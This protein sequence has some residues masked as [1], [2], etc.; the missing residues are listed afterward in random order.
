MSYSGN[1]KTVALNKT[2]HSIRNAQAILQYG[3]GAMIDFPDQT[4]MTT[5][6]KYWDD[7]ITKIHDERL[8]KRLKVG[9]FGSPKNGK[10]NWG[11]AFTRFPEWYFCPKCRFF[12]PIK[13]WNKD[14]LKAN[15]KSEIKIMKTPK[16]SNCR[17]NLVPARIVTACTDGHIN[18]FPWIEW[19]HN[20]RG[21][22]ICDNP[23]LK[24]TMTQTSSVGLEGVST[25]CTNCDSYATLKGAFDQNIFNHLAEKYGEAYYCNGGMPWK[26]KKEKCILFPKVLQRGSSSMYFPSIISSLVIPP[27]SEKIVYE[28]EKSNQFSKILT[29][30]EDYDD[31]EFEKRVNQ[32]IDNWTEQ[33]FEE[34]GLGTFEAIK[35]ILLRKINIDKSED[36]EII[37]NLDYKYEEYQALNGEIMSSNSLDNDFLREEIS[38]NK[39]KLPFIKQLSLVH[40]IREVRALT[41]FSRVIPA[42]NEE[43]SEKNSNIMTIKE[44]NLDWY[45]AYEVRGEGIFLEFKDELIKK[46][47]ESSDEI[48]AR[49]EILKNNY[50]KSFMGQNTKKNI[51]PKYVLLHTIAHSLIAQ[52][53]FECGYTNASLRE[54][55]YCDDNQEEE[56]SF[57]K[58]SGIFIYTSS[59]D[60]EGTLGGLVLQGEYNSFWKIFDK[61][62]DSLRFCSNDP[63]C[64]N[65][66][67]QGRESLNLASCH[68][69]TLLPE[70]CCEE[71]N[72]F[73]DRVLLIG[74]LN[75]PNLG[76][77]NYIN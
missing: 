22:E 70:T 31:E 72:V 3:V 49:I 24:F 13:L 73:L 17:I 77:F 36:D 62:I 47:I 55:I 32:K 33:V 20:Q 43:E 6:H 25:L 51:S 7:N 61:A 18:D 56:I 46:W 68:T 67:G 2:S 76:F 71:Y 44:K 28:I 11:I 41:G 14:F 23:T 1:K 60:S 59:G 69:C 4:L 5:S 38:F 42:G 39:E 21:K 74:K 27:Y 48:I 53:S 75:N 10:D 63:I 37:K 40:K 19:T 50:K 16:C 30:L 12:K 29:I 52:L 9:Y 15:S 26:N 64:N 45:P 66:D 57:K 34:I 65:S 54:R 35:E 8:S 58:M